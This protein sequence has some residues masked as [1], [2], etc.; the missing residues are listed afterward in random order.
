[1]HTMKPNPT[2]R[3]PGAPGSPGP[4]SVSGYTL[5]EVLIIVTIIGIAA[6]IVVPN[7]LAAG[8]L[9]VQAAARIIISDILYA[10]ND[11]IAQQDNRRVVFDPDNESYRLA[12]DSGVTLT[13]KWKNGSNSNYIVDFTSDS[14]F[15]GVVIASADFGGTPT[16][17]FDALGGPLN[18]GTVEIEF[19]GT[20][21]RITVAAFTGRVTVQQL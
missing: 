7:M 16:L 15:Q 19:Q 14:R 4:R 9:G 18:G 3:I 21:Y 13:A 11:A 10:Q 20:R 1:M 12:D 2:R 6:A 8:T 5:V 17:E